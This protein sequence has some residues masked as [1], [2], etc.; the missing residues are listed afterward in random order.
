MSNATTT[1]SEEK[2]RVLPV[3]VMGAAGQSHQLG[4]RYADDCRVVASQGRPQYRGRMRLEF[5]SRERRGRGETCVF[6]LCG[7]VVA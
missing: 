4:V 6:E 7:E 1:A 5:R 2:W 3:A